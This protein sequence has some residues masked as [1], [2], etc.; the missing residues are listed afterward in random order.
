M[1]AYF[2]EGKHN[3]LLTTISKSGST[4]KVIQ[5]VKNTLVQTL[6]KSRKRTNCKA[7]KKIKHNGGLTEHV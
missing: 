6:N 3:I 2:D 4:T 1:I 7:L 5:L